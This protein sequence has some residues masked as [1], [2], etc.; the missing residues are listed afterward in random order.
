ME[1]LDANRNI[2]AYSVKL[3]ELAGRIDASYHFP[4]INAITGHLRTNAAEVTTVG[5]K[6]VSKDIILPGRFKRI[7]VDEGQGRVFIG[8]KQI[9]E[10]DPYGK[11]YLSFVHHGDR[12]KKQL[13]LAENMILITCSGTIGKVTLVPHHWNHWAANQHIIRVIPSTK[14]IAGYAYIFLASDYGRQLITR[15]T[16]GSVVDEIDDNHV[17]QTP[18]PLLKNKSIQAE[19][20]HLALKANELR[21]QAYQL[22]QEAMRLLENEVT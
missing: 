22:E 13:E 18:F 5:D 3:S 21:Y 15:F 20:N 7:Y 6:R 11:K 9:Y 2:N 10:L 19:I 1:Q 4:I 8:G 12:I 16:Y 14:D 17:S